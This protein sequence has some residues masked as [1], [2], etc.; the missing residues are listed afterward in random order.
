VRGLFALEE[1]RDRAAPLLSQLRAG[2]RRW[3]D[4]SGSE[5]QIL[6]RGPL[7]DFLLETSYSLRFDNPRAMLSFARA[8]C[9]V[10]DGMDPKRYGKQ[11]VTDLRAGA[12]VELA[13]A[14]R[15]FEDL[16]RQG[17]LLREPRN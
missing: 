1:D 2:T 10:A 8:A 5:H 4:L 15:V 6:S 12:W 14:C 9:A 11:V 17:P 7:I 3:E 16:T 13:N